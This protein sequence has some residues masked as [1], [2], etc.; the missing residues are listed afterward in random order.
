[1]QKIPLRKIVPGVLAV[2]TTLLLQ[3]CG[4]G[5]G[6][7][8]PTP[9]PT[10]TTPPPPPV[11]TTPINGGGVKGPL[12]NAV[13]T[14]YSLDFAQ[15]DFKG[16]VVATGT[17]ND[18]AQI[19]GLDLTDATQTYILEVTS[20][21]GQTTDI[22]TDAFP[23][24]S[25]LRTIMRDIDSVS[26]YS[27]YATPI[28]TVVTDLAILNADLGT[29]FGGNQD[30]TVTAAEFDD[31]LEAAERRVKSTLGFGLTE[32]IDVFEID[33]IITSETDTDAEQ[34]ET[35]AYRTAV[36]ALTTLVVEVSNS[37]TGT[38]D[39]VVAEI[40]R[41]IA[42][43]V[44]DAQSMGA[45][46]SA[47]DATAVPVFGRD[48][49]SLTIPNTTTLVSEVGQILVDEKQKTGATVDTT[50]LENAAFD[51]RPADLDEDLDDDGVINLTD[52]FPHDENE[53]EDTDGDRIGNNE[54]DD[55]DNDGVPDALDPF[56]RDETENSDLDNDG[57]GDNADRDDD[58]DGVD[59]EEDDFPHDSERSQ[60]VDLDE[61]GWPAEDDPDDEDPNVP[62]GEFE[63]HD[64]DGV[65]DADDDDDDDDGVPDDI[66]AFPFDAAEHSDLDGDGI[67]DHADDDRDGDGTLNDD[68]DFPSDEAEDH[69]NDRD[70]VGDRRDDDDDNDGVSDDEDEFPNDP[71]ESHD[72]D[73]DGIGDNRDPDDDNDGVDDDEDAFPHD[74]NESEDSDG[75]GIGDN[76]DDDDGDDGSDGDG[77]SD[78]DSD[79]SSTD[80]G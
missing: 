22:T 75:D 72:S 34:A 11:T 76:A 51:V 38:A 16:A 13:V 49:A 36:E 42:D 12:A 3:G 17:T 54:D 59:D 19:V 68:D 4:G 25:T 8:T 10:T 52:A 70:G 41:D 35:L 45:A 21:A 20:V 43:G 73:G 24:I 71:E 79:D 60:K 9:E 47:Y 18:A 58:G 48:P 15:A 78:D 32:E 14:V 80:D 61:D 64:G 55:D 44:L 65:R 66:D 29:P 1:M 26:D 28:T 63:D 74:R 40:S 67:G 39:E 5:G 23:V 2:T 56:P 53:F 37:S 30:G 69:D 77:T 6:S 33:P 31:A 57:I 7:T 50:D 62:V 46:S 27:V